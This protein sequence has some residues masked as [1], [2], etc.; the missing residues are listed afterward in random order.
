MTLKNP[1]GDSSLK[2][3]S[4]RLAVDSSPQTTQGI[5]TPN[6]VPVPGKLP[7]TVLATVLVV[8]P[9][10]LDRRL[11]VLDESLNSV[12]QADEDQ[13]VVGSANRTLL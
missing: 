1:R 9:L 7:D 6:L 12:L 10:V 8:C 4:T 2:I 11:K 5:R 13:E 3:G